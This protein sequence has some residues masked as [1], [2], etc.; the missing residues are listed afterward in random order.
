MLEPNDLLRLTALM[1][2]NQHG[3]KT[4]APAWLRSVLN[5]EEC[6]A[7]YSER[8]GTIVENGIKS[9]PDESCCP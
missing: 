1:S 8:L 3:Q 7:D 9:Y 2:R 4:G 6:E 5:V